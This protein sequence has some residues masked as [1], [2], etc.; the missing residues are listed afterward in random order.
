MNICKLWL[1]Q[2]MMSPERIALVD[3]QNKYTYNNINIWSDYI[4]SQLIKKCECSGKVIGLF[5]SNSIEYIVAALAVLKVGA[6]FVPLDIMWPLERIQYV[7]E[8]C[9]AVGVINGDKYYS[10]KKI[11]FFLI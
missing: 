4:S 7:V 2:V 10:E 3:N 6:A 5:F 9:H 8:D 1:N 11:F